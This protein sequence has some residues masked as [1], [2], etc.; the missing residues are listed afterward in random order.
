MMRQSRNYG[1]SPPEILRTHPFETTRIAEA[2]ARADSVTVAA[3]PPA[4][5]PS[6][7]KSLDNRFELF[8]ERLRVLMETAG[9]NLVNRYRE[10]LKVDPGDPFERYGLA[11]SLSRREAYKEAETVT[12]QLL[13]DHPDTMAFALLMA[14]IEGRTGREGDAL[15]RYAGLHDHYPDRAAI[16]APYAELLL[17]D[18]DAEQARE[19]ARLLRPL[20]DRDTDHAQLYSLIGRAYEVSG[21]AIRAAE[22]HA[23]SAAYNGR[24][25]DSLV[26]FERLQRRSDLDYYQRARVQARI[27]ELTPIVMEIRRRFINPGT[28]G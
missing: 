27:T 6:T 8:R 16:L 13:S 10:R 4:A 3:R 17:K 15:A 21:D 5:D 19:A 28:A 24:F 26:Q 7:L 22:S 2:K 12:A 14:H 18:R 20:I 11:L 25:E 23:L 9:D 1:L